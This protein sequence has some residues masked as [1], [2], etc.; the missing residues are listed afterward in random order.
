M[1]T[2]IHTI[3]SAVPTHSYH[4]SIQALPQTNHSN[5]HSNQSKPFS[6]L[7]LLPSLRIRHRNPVLPLTLSPLSYL[8][9]K[10]LLPEH[11]QVHIA[12]LQPSVHR[13]RHQRLH[14][15]K[16]ASLQ[17]RPFPSPLF[18]L[19]LLPRTLYGAITTSGFRWCRRSSAAKL[20]EPFASRLP[21]RRISSVRFRRRSSD[22]PYDTPSPRGYIV[23][24][25]RVLVVA[26]HPHQVLHV[27][28]PLPLEDRQ[29]RGNALL[30]RPDED[31]P[32]GDHAPRE[33]QPLQLQVGKIA[34]GVHVHHLDRQRTAGI[35]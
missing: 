9:R 14:R 31:E 22:D 20:T 32:R 10:P 4:I 17:Q 34:G 30:V 27:E 35:R 15:R 11:L 1:I 21:R 13:P 2:H 33:L 29:H 25:D 8:P 19:S 16:H 24:W 26:A 7:F 3:H 6:S 12:V 23:Q 28:E 18:S 5:K